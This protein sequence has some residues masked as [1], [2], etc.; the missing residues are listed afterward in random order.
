MIKILELEINEFR[1]IPHLALT[2]NGKSFAIYGPNGSGKSGVVDA[3]DF[4]FSGTI[5]RLSGSGMAGV[6]IQKHGPHVRSRDEPG[7]AWVKLKFLDTTSGKIGTI[8][9]T[10]EHPKQVNLDPDTPTLRS[11]LEN[12]GQHPE[13]TLSRRNLINFILTEPS[14]RAEQVQALLQLD[15]LGGQRKA[16]KSAVTKLKQERTGAESAQAN[17]QSALLRHL[18]IHEFTND[19]ILSLINQ[20]RGIVGVPEIETLNGNTNF[21][22]GIEVD[23]VPFDKLSALRD[24]RALIA[25][26]ENTQQLDTAMSR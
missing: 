24:T 6:S 18:G 12:M 17:A 16:L 22:E 26:R 23:G 9:R 5:A 19:K 8:L 13:V 25:S 3:I 10:V 4:A 2:M 14:K 7:K 21:K 20:K 15:S 1:G 11:V